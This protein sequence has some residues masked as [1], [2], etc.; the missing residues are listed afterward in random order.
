MKNKIL[1]FLLEL[2]I[3]SAF[4]LVGKYISDSYFSGWVFGSLSMV[5]VTLIDKIR[6]IKCEEKSEQ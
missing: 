2:F 6:K 3:F 4:Y 5:V 1:N